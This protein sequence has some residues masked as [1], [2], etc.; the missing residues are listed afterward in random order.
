LALASNVDLGLTLSSTVANWY[1]TD[2]ARNSPAPFNFLI[3]TG[4]FTFLS[5]VYLTIVSRFVPKAHHPFAALVGVTLPISPF[6]RELCLT[7]WLQGIEAITMIF[8]FA[9]FIA[10][11][12]FLANLLFCRGSVCNAARADAAFSALG[13]LVWTA[14]TALTAMD[15][16]KTRRW[17]GPGVSRLPETSQKTTA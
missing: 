3:F 11:S 17:G 9:G 8:Y 16:W 12:I 4:I 2:T 7:V 1:N 13:W 5:L 14:S 10:L 15:V 6:A